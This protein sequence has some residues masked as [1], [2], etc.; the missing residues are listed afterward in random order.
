VKPDTLAV[1]FI[2][3]DEEPVLGR[4]LGDARSFADEIVVVDTGSS[5]RTAQI[6]RF[7]GARL[8]EY[9][10]RDDFAGARN[11]AFDRCTTEWVMWLDADDRVPARS[12]AAFVDAKLRLSRSDAEA[13]YAPY[14]LE[15]VDETEGSYRACTHRVRVVRRDRNFRWEGRI[16]ENLNIGDAHAVWLQQIWVEHRP[17]SGHKDNKR[18]RDRRI[19]E[20]LIW[21]GDRS[22][23]VLLHY[24][25]L[26]AGSGEH[27]VAA[28]VLE[29]CLVVCL[30]VAP[31]Y[32]AL[33][34][35][36]ACAEGLGD[37]GRR[38]ECLY[39][40]LDVD[41]QR[42]EAFVDLGNLHEAV[43]DYAGAMP[44]FRAAVG[45]TPPKV[46]I[47]MASAYSWAPLVGLA[48]CASQLGRPLERLKWLEQAAS[49]APHHADAIRWLEG[50]DDP[51]EAA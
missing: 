46:G 6:A 3:R 34:T 22:P 32:V 23:M 7:Y 45:L 21:E 35:L 37:G 48:R 12:Q 40:A 20:T 49:A 2:V 10:W 4:V 13:A 27:E 28:A 47:Y 24:G 41:S 31:R 42:A 11:E 17:V 25:M 8:Y 16:H 26:L 19:L 39:E 44:F 18:I 5:D 33:M 36:A 43:G 15:Y 29:E 30:A 1:A 9:E 51:G 14:R 50:V 38:A